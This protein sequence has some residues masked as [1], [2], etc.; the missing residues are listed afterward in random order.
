[1]IF[2]KLFHIETEIMKI[3]DV[4]GVWPLHGVA[5]TWGGLAC[6]IFGQKFFGGMGGVNF[7]SQLIGSLAAV[8]FALICSAVIY[9]LLNGLAGIRLGNHEELMGADLSIHRIEAYPEE[10][11]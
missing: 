9:K 6:G 1:M 8:I 7:M 4:L 2:V 10:A 5:G 3:D 11:L